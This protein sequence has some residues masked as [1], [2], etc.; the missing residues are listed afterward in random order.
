MPSLFPAST[1]CLHD[2]HTAGKAHAL[3]IFS[4]S[5]WK[6]KTNLSLAAL[7][8]WHGYDLSFFLPKWVSLKRLSSVAWPLRSWLYKQENLF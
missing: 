4:L 8:R 1:I 2:G 3:C 7:L 6:R 5:N